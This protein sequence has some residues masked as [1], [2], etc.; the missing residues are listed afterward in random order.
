MHG[1]FVI[2]CQQVITAAATQMA[3]LASNVGW[4]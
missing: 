3:L 2:T 4:K 1:N